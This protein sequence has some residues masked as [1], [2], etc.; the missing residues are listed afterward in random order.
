MLQQFFL[1][2]NRCARQRF[3]LGISLFIQKMMPTPALESQSKKISRFSEEGF[4]EEVPDNDTLLVDTEG[5]FVKRSH[6]QLINRL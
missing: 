1:L 5:R 2:E 3:M 4:I 6:S